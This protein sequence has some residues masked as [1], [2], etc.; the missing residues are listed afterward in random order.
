MAD[1]EGEG[2]RMVQAE[3]VTGQCEV[4]EAGDEVEGELEGSEELKEKAEEYGSLVERGVLV[5]C[6]GLHQGQAMLDRVGP[7]A[8]FGEEKGRERVAEGGTEKR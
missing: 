2:L 5:V 3:F 8:D 1:M 7:D 6:G 4:I